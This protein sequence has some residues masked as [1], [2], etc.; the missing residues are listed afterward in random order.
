MQVDSEEALAVYAESEAQNLVRYARVHLGVVDGEDVVQDLLLWALPRVRNGE[1]YFSKYL[2]WRLLSL[3]RSQR[4]SERQRGE[5]VD[6][7]ALESTNLQV[8]DLES[9]LVEREGDM[10]AT[11]RLRWALGQVSERDRQALTLRYLDGISREECAERMGLSLGTFDVALLRARDRLAS[12]H[13]S[14]GR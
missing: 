3:A 7:L 1:R 12:V 5:L 9:L 10:V 14:H 2:R 13:A 6:A 4:V 8:G 11:D